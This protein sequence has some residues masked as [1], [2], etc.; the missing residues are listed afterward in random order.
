MDT[1]LDTVLIIRNLA[2]FDAREATP[3]IVECRRYAV[4]ALYGLANA[5]DTEAKAALDARW[6][7]HLARAATQGPS[8]PAN[9]VW[10]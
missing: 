8:T 6:E 10:D 7:R 2:A 1:P 9:N 4:E 3:F 5:G